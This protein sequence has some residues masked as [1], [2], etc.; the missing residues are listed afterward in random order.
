MKQS[1]PEKSLGLGRKYSEIEADCNDGTLTK[2]ERTRKTG[3]E[4][5]SLTVPQCI[6]D[7][8][9]M[10]TNYHYF[11]HCDMLELELFYG[12]FMHVLISVK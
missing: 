11:R 12:L 4:P 1:G 7:P 5:T 9:R 6:R 2:R 10:I 8:A 3:L